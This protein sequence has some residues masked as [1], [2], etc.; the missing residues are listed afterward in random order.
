[1]AASP[2]VSARRPMALMKLVSTRLKSSSAWAW[3]MPNTASASVLPLMCGMPKSSRVMVTAA[4]RAAHRFMSG[5]SAAKA[6][7]ASSVPRSR[8]RM[9][10]RQG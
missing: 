1:M 6:G 2:S 7:A 9:I 5:L 3:I 8:A 4:L 10:M